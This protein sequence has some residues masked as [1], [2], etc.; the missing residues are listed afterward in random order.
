[1]RRTTARAGGA[2]TGG[3]GERAA[4]AKQAFPGVPIGWR[5]ARAM[6]GGPSEEARPSAGEGLSPQATLRPGMHGGLHSRLVE[7]LLLVGFESLGEPRAML[8]TIVVALSDERLVVRLELREER[9][10][11]QRLRRH[12]SARAGHRL[13]ALQAGPSLD[14]VGWAEVCRAL[15]SY[16]S[17]FL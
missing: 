16:S 8:R 12:R 13:L 10:D 2:G 11:I 17:A 4:A 15:W 3:G 6:V 9:P 1:M 14:Q 7:Q 5:K